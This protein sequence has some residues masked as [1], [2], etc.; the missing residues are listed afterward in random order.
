MKCSILYGRRHGYLPYRMRNLI[1]RVVSLMVAIENFLFLGFFYSF[2]ESAVLF[3]FFLG[4]TG[5]L[6]DMPA[7]TSHNLLQKV[8]RFGMSVE[9]PQKSGGS[10]LMMEFGFSFC[11][12][13]ASDLLHLLYRLGNLISFG[14]CY[15]A[16]NLAVYQK[17]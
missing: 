5:G 15:N 7:L 12:S 2:L 10:F 11:V 4:L 1:F 14:T 6:E 9:K 13:G 16:M 3:F 8:P 17:F